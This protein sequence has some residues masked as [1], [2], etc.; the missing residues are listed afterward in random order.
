MN[1]LKSL[2]PILVLLVTAA[3]VAAQDIFEV[4]KGLFSTRELE[5]DYE[6]DSQR[7]LII[8]SA[9]NLGGKLTIKT[10]NQKTINIIYTKQ[11]R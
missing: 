9:I 1:P 4:E 3:S 6:L 8:K 2:I 7:Q 5:M 11:A 10:A